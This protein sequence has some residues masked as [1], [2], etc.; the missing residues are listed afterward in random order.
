MARHEVLSPKER[1]V[2]RAIVA[3]EGD[4]AHYWPVDEVPAVGD[5]GNGTQIL[6]R[7]YAPVNVDLAGLWRELGVAMSSASVGFD[8]S[9]P[10]ASTRRAITAPELR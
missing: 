4:V 9:A 5:E 10:L 1:Q 8:D 7:V 6:A 3:S 2:L